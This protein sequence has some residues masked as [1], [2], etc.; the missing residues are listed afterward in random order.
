[1]VLAVL[2]PGPAHGAGA[3]AVTVEERLRR[4]EA[5]VHELR[6]E[7]A[8]LR[9]E[10]RGDA[11]VRSVPA[12]AA[13]PAAVKSGGPTLRIASDVRLRWQTTAYE[14]AVATRDQ[15]YYQLHALFSASVSDTLDAAFR[16]SAGDLNAGFGG[17]PLSAQ[18]GFADNA[19]RKY[20][21]LDQGYLRWKPQLAPDVRATFSIGKVENV[22]Y[23]PSRLL[24]DSDYMPEGVTEEITWQLTPRDRVWAAA[25]QYLVDELTG[26]TRDPWM[27]AVRGRWER[28]WGGDWSTV[29][30][31]GRLVI[32]HPE[33]LTAGN[34]ANSN[35][36]NT[37]TPAGLLAHGLR[38]FYAEAAVTRGI[39]GVPGFAGKFP[40]TVAGDFIHNPAAPAQRDG[41]SLGLTLGKA[42]AAG[43][44]EAGYRFMRIEADAWWEELLDADHAGYYRSVPPGWNNDPASLAGGHGGGTNIRAHIVRLGYSPRDYLLF[45]T[46]LFLGDL[47]RKFPAG[48]ND[49]GTTRLQVETTV[50]F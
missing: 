23:G 43:Q 13:S 17:P 30:G 38:P 46:N 8:A 31:G 7:N 26:S 2:W 44:W 41:W 32:T 42:G 49:T 22:F 5:T 47:I 1:V 15:V 27:I 14:A 20:V 6:E 28:N 34:V 50:R 37:R 11:A 39:G 35:R 18:F 25:G 33:A 4:L 40:V 3:E 21:F 19:A 29:L 24:F 10:L 9:R 36:G 45:T 16:L 48:A 12:T